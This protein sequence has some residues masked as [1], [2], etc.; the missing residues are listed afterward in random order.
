[1]KTRKLVGFEGDQLTQQNDW[2]K[3][4]KDGWKTAKTLVCLTDASLVGLFPSIS[5]LADDIVTR[6]PKILRHREPS[7]QPVGFLID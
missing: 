3:Y 5:R 6:G 7:V 4:E 2:W 1:M